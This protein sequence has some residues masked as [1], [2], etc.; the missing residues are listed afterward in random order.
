MQTHDFAGDPRKHPV[1]ETIT[2]KL[3]NI[4]DI[5]HARHWTNFIMNLIAARGAYCFFN[6]KPAGKV[7]FEPQFERLVFRSSIL[8]QYRK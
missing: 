1:I 7:D 8:T 6:K 5:E 4:C 2:D 3:K